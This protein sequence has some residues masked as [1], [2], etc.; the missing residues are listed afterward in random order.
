[1]VGRFVLWAKKYFKP[2]NMP[3]NN[4]FEI[5]IER[6]CEESLIYTWELFVD[7]QIAYFELNERSH[8][9]VNA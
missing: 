6:N 4:F 7:S 1:M 3:N 9:Y 2:T 8:K 5:A